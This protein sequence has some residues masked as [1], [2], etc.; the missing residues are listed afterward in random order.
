MAGKQTIS[1]LIAMAVGGGPV[2][3]LAET[4]TADA[5]LSPPVAA[6]RA[7]PYPPVPDIDTGDP[8]MGEGDFGGPEQA[9]EDLAEGKVNAIMGKADTGLNGEDDDGPAIVQDSRNRQVIKLTDNDWGHGR[10]GGC[11]GCGRC[12]GGRRA[13]AAATSGAGELPFT[14]APVALIATMGAGLLAVGAAGTLISVRR[15]RS[16]GVR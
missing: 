6:L 16:S 4:A 5:D 11:G 13:T 7:H 3:G 12:G 1:L 9:I 15:R 14:G 10:C 2:L 8:F